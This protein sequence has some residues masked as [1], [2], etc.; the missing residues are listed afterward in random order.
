MQKCP[1]DGHLF[2]VRLV[3]SATVVN[4]AAEIAQVVDEGVELCDIVSDVPNT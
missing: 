4:E 1:G 3:R 2:V